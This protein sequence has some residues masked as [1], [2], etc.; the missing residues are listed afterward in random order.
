ME[1]V[2]LLNKLP[3]TTSQSITLPIG[4]KPEMMKSNLAKGFYKGEMETLNKQSFA[5]PE[6]NITR[7]RQWP[8]TWSG[9]QEKFADVLHKPIKRSFTRR[10][11][12]VNNSDEIWSICYRCIL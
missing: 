8:S 3:E 11:V 6:K 12:T 7:S 2:A 1:D 10:R 4:Y 5:P 9:W